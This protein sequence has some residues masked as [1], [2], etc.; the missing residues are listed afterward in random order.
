MKD[1]LLQ[2]D[3]TINALWIWGTGLISS[4]RSH[5]FTLW[6]R[7]KMHHLVPSPL[8]ML[9]S[10]CVHVGLLKLLQDPFTRVQLSL[11]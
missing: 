3:V 2:E 7:A 6:T 10:M 11:P 8:F 1:F 4:L 9:V 5:S